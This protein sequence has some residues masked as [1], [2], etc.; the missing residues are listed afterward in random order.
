M[1][2]RREGT[3]DNVDS[4]HREEK[5]LA[6]E[7]EREVESKCEERG[8]VPTACMNSPSELPLPIAPQVGSGDLTMHRTARL[9]LLRAIA[10]RHPGR[11]GLWISSGS[12]PDQRPAIV[13]KSH[14]ST[15]KGPDMKR[16][17]LNSH[18]GAMASVLTLIEATIFCC[19]FWGV[20]D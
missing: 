11:G 8:R 17:S 10:S 9:S 15:T 20:L 4:F 14:C 12:G 1:C 5:M 16:S 7:F 13:P 18:T 19:G 6:E 2:Q 3:R